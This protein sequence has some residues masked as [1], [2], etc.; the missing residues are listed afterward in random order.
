M[1]IANKSSVILLPL[2]ETL[3]KRVYNETID[4]S[5]FVKQ[6]QLVGRDGR[7]VVEH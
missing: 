7:M 2:D 3:E 6:T 4:L 1:W 5:I